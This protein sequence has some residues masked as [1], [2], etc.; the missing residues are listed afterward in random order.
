MKRVISLVVLSVV[1]ML[2]Y[3]QQRGASNFNTEEFPTVS[4]TWNDYNPDVISA[5]QVSLKEDDKACSFV[6]DNVAPSRSVDKSKSIVIL[7]EDMAS[8]SGQSD[9][10]SAMLRSFFSFGVQKNDC[11]NI[12]AFNRDKGNGQFMQSVTDGFISD[13]TEMVKAIYTHKNSTDKFGTNPYSANIYQAVNEAI[14]L[15]EKEPKENLK[16]IILVSAGMN[17]NTAGAPKDFVSAEALKRNI[18][19]YVVKYP[20]NNDRS[21]KDVEG[22]EK[23]TYGELIV[24]ANTQDYSSVAKRLNEAYQ[25]MS[26]R[27]YGQDYTVTFASSVK[28]DGKSHNLILSIN[29]EDHRIAYT[30]PDFSLMVWIQENLVLAIAIGSGVLLLIVLIIILIVYKAKKRKSKDLAFQKKNEQLQEQMDAQKK[31]LQDKLEEERKMREDAAQAEK[32]R[33]E[34]EALAKRQKE[35]S[36]IMHAKNLYPRLVF[37]F[38]GE[39]RSEMIAN[40]VTEIGRDRSNDIVI[41][42]PTVS[43]KHAIISFNGSGFEIENVSKTNKTIVNGQFVE[44]QVL[45]ANDIIGIGE[46]VINFYI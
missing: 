18:P 32:V 40:P 26:A 12:I 15:L 29:G 3:A 10:I 25:H 8:H 36:D 22:I 13:P 5:N 21:R 23:I 41:N 34:Q 4:F 1:V 33:L 24:P 2:S 46:I 42:K 14:A 11:F 17:M 7:W 6:W 38:D 35:L 20:L 43:R 9:F 30:A 31:A 45:K 27:H 19:I 16:A 37:T 44:K 28:R 39:N